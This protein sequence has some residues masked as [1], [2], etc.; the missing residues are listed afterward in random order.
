M[1]TWIIQISI[2]SA[3]FIFLIHHLFTFFITTLT[4]PK[5][6]DL[7]NTSNQK[8]QNIYDTISHNSNSYTNIDLLPT[9][10]DDPTD[11]KNELKQFLKSQLNN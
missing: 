2:F 1:L 10:C 7:V 5:V 4:V 3:L 6:K 11:M 8:Y 9:T